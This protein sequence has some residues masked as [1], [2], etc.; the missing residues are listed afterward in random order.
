MSDV[1]V[2]VVD[3]NELLRRQVVRLI[4]KS[5][6]LVV[7][8]EAAD[9]SQAALAARKARPDVVL[10][11]VAMPVVDGIDATREIVATC[12]MCRVLGF[13]EHA[14]A[15]FVS[16]MRAAGAAGYMLKHNVKEELE[17]AVRTVAAGGTFMGHGVQE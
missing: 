15:T 4:G 7:V 11:D 13:S 14:S 2:L 8:G 16:A 1:W 10:M 12:P 3:D 6:G 5:R 17:Q 9:G